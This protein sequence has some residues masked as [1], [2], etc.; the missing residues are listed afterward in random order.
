M[1]RG[2][3][4]EGIDFADAMCRG[5]IV[6]GIPYPGLKDPG[7]ILKR[8]FNTAHKELLNG[9]E[10][11][12]GEAF[13]GLNQAL[14]RAI[15]HVNDYGAILLLDSRFHAPK[16]Q[17]YLSRWVQGNVANADSAR[18][19][20]MALKD[21]FDPD[22]GAPSLVPTPVI[23]EE[24]K[25]GGPPVLKSGGRGRGRGRGRGGR[26]KKNSGAGRGRGRGRGTNAGFVAPKRKTPASQ[27][28]PGGMRSVKPRQ[29]T[30]KKGGAGYGGFFVPGKTMP[31]L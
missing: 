18:E 22:M 2:K 8:E 16:Y 12:D 26:K 17:R 3:I 23:P 25:N 19:T 6:L 4:S 20:A 13:R 21:F 1:A 28:Q 29:G 5:C 24:W 14:G 31:G 9:S 15:R 7:V 11:F 10:W 27:A 30:T